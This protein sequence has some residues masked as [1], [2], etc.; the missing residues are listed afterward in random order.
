MSFG[1]DLMNWLSDPFGVKAG[2]NAGTGVIPT[3]QE[4][5]GG[6]QVLSAQQYAQTYGANGR[7]DTSLPQPGA[8]DDAAAVRNRV[9]QASPQNAQ[10]Y[11]DNVASLKTPAQSAGTDAGAQSPATPTVTGA[12]PISMVPSITTATGQTL[13]NPFYANGG[14]RPDSAAYAQTLGLPAGAALPY[15][16]NQ[17]IPWNVNTKS[18]VDPSTFA[19]QSVGGVDADYLASLRADF[20]KSRR[21]DLRQSGMDLID[22]YAS[23]GIWSPDDQAALLDY[24]GRLSPQAAANLQDQFNQARNVPGAL[25]DGVT[26][27]NPMSAEDWTT[28]L[29]AD[30]YKQYAAGLPV[31]PAELDTTPNA[32]D[33][34]SFMDQLHAALGD[35]AYNN[36]IGG[37]A[38]TTNPQ[39]SQIGADLIAAIL[40]M[41][42]SQGQDQQPYTAAAVNQQPAMT[43][44]RYA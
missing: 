38:S 12:Q 32:T 13:S 9:M 31:L 5:A 7:T 11:A 4:R 39:S 44:I 6:R 30:V 21:G 36:L 33:S 29:G 37:N 43:A 27:L 10:T 23:G 8:S 3:R 41:S 42:N 35:S 15:W 24:T 34:T 26:W 28:A 18:F 2:R 22:K 25:P 17:G 20:E 40:G 19:T 16:T 1:S 14:M